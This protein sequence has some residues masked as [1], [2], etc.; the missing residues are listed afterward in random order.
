MQDLTEKILSCKKCSGLN[1]LTNKTLVSPG[2][3][4]IKSKVIFYGSSVGGS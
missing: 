4:N 3:G 1:C 2:Y